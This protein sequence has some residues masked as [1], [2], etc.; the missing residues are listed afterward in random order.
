MRAV[1]L[2]ALTAAQLQVGTK[3][4]SITLDLGFPPEKIDLAKRVA[5]KEV[6]IVG[7]PGA[8]TPT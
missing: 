3:I 4:P 6:V 2:F 8:F 1:A 7:L 5:G